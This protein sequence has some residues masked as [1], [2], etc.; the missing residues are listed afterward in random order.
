MRVRG[1]GELQGSRKW[2]WWSVVSLA[3]EKKTQDDRP[4]HLADAIA[5]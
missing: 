5:E 1:F 3:V 2:W 4:A